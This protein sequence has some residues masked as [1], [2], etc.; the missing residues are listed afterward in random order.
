MSYHFVLD[1]QTNCSLCG[2]G[3]ANLVQMSPT[4]DPGGRHDVA[5]CPWCLAQAVQTLAEGNST[6]S[7]REAR[8]AGRTVKHPGEIEDEEARKRIDDAIRRGK[9][10]F[11]KKS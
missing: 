1:G 4:D 11:E 6:F 7:T 5:L 8:D 10:V 2:Y 3:D 9:G